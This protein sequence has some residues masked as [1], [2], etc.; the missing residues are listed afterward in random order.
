MKKSLRAALLAIAIFLVIGACVFFTLHQAKKQVIPPVTNIDQ[1]TTDAEA[2]AIKKAATQSADEGRSTE[3]RV[4]APIPDQYFPPPS[5]NLSGGKIG[6]QQVPY[7]DTIGDI[8]QTLF[9]LPTYTLFMAVTEPNG[10]RAIWQ[11]KEHAKPERVM[12]AGTA[13]GDIAVFGGSRGEIYVQYDNPCQLFRS[14]D[15]LKTWRLVHES[16]CMFWNMAD[17]GKGNVYAALHDWNTAVL[18]RSQDDGFTWEAWKDFQKLFPAYAAPYADGDNRFKL[19]HLHDVIYDPQSDRLVVG[20]GDVARFA[21]ESADDG[22]TWKQIWDEGFT[23]H[24]AMSGGDRYLLGP[25]QLHSHG[26]GLYD[27][28]KGTVTEVWNPT[29]YNFAGYCYSIVN[30]DGVYYAAFHTEA[31]EVDSV[32]PTFGVIVSPDGINW[33]RFMEWGPLGHHARTDIWLTP[34]P[35]LVYAS[36]NGA[37]YAFRPLDKA[38]FSD[39]LPFGAEAAGNAIP[40]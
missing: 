17:D 25:D 9:Y 28:R 39:K 15:G 3:I 20:T 33:Y 24:V 29:P 14:G 10:M 8:H 21:F 5:V 18:Y 27:V 38:W 2:E 26:I 36:V 19:R 35:G 7:T 22:N 40:K 13:K 30:V 1:A 37:L 4:A 31:N 11:L 12:A 23:S 16:P 6:N 32:V 34:A